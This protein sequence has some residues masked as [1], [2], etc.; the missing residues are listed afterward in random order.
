MVML[1]YSFVEN[2]SIMRQLK[3][4]LLIV[5]FICIGANAQIITP[6]KWQVSIE[7]KSNTDYLLTFNGTIE[8]DW[9]LYS[10]VTLKGGAATLQLLFPNSKN[11]FSIVGKATESATTSKFNDVFGVNENFFIDKAELQQRIVVT[12]PNN[13]LIQVE[14]VYQ[15]CKEVC[16]P[17]RTYFEFDISKL[18]GKNV[19]SFIP[20]KRETEKQSVVEKQ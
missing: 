3:H 18:D 6:V 12:E 16:V 2:F 20:K 19:K 14:L 8:K 15:V 7:K 13:K 17:Q 10:Q 1:R 11:N 9:H 4:I 5:L